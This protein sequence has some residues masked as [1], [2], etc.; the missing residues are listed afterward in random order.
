MSM[1]YPL[2]LYDKIVSC[3][4][5]D[6]L[7]LEHYCAL[8]QVVEEVMTLVMVM[9]ILVITMTVITTTVMLMTV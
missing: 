9:V 4:F 6:K 2:H 3:D 8:Q 5:I 7:Q 1:C